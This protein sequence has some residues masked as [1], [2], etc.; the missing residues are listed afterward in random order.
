MKIEM[1][2]KYQTGPGTPI[3]M[4]NAEHRIGYWNE[5]NSCVCAY[6]GEHAV[7]VYAIWRR[8]GM[9]W[10]KK[11]SDGWCG[12]FWMHQLIYE[13]KNERKAK[14]NICY[15]LLD[16]ELMKWSSS[17]SSIIIRLLLEGINKLNMRFFYYLIA[18]QGKQNKKNEWK[19][20][21]KTLYT[22][23]NSCYMHQVLIYQI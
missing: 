20:E 9:K 3:N 14:T 19:R 1:G 13:K 23:T 4:S 2:R 8:L 12:N 18:N 17:K 21:I 16:L 11:S 10:K 5:N 15:H 7:C 6:T 22:I